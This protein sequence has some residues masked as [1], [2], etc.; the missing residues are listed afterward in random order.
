MMCT[1]GH[2]TV[3]EKYE[4]VSAYCMNRSDTNHDCDR[5]KIFHGP[6][7][8]ETFEAVRGDVGYCKV[9]DELKKERHNL[10]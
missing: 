6:N 8:N 1:F 3:Y 5:Y 2:W 4:L 10:W 7:R 9:L